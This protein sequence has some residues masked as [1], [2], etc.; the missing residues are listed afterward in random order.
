MNARKPSFPFHAEIEMTKLI[1]NV[2]AGACLAVAASLAGAAPAAA[3]VVTMAADVWCPYNCRPDTEHPGFAIEMARAILE[4]QG[5]KVEYIVIPWAR[6]LEEVRAGKIEPPRVCR[7][8]NS[9]SQAANVRPF[10]CA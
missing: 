1:I 7:R 5:R 3:E 9:S 8:P 2:A 10:I 4:P 6:T